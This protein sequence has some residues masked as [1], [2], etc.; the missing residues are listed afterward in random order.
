MEEAAKVAAETKTEEHAEPKDKEDY[1]IGRDYVKR[2]LDCSPHQEIDFFHR[3]MCHVCSITQI[4]TSQSKGN[5]NS[6]AYQPADDLWGWIPDQS[7]RLRRFDKP[8]KTAKETVTRDPWQGSR[9]DWRP[10]KDINVPFRHFT[11][12]K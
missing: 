9:V 11:D 7:V 1:L 4:K 5:K 12:D 8:T 3:K 10:S 2:L 6:H